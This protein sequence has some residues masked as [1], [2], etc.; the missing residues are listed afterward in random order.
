MR[1]FH[2]ITIHQCLQETLLGSA[3]CIHIVLTSD[4]F[5]FPSIWSA[6]TILDVAQ[7]RTLLTTVSRSQ[8]CQFSLHLS[9][10]L[11]YTW[12]F[13]L[14]TAYCLNLCL[15]KL[16]MLCNYSTTGTFVV[17]I[18]TVGLITHSFVLSSINI[19][20]FTI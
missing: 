10:M 6:C 9:Y 19:S 5:W 3:A 18:F 1:G 14:I 11:H 20:T 15:S 17:K 7:G 12:S 8:C 2:P 4:Q 16:H 13:W